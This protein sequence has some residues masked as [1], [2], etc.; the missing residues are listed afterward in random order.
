MV[1]LGPLLFLLGLGPLLA[2]LAPHKMEGQISLPIP[3]W[4]GEY[5]KVVEEEL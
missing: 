2:L 1:E 4:I 5:K 3:T